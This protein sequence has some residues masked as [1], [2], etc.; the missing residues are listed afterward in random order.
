MF[1]LSN[2]F[3]VDWEFLTELLGDSMNDITSFRE[4]FLLEIR[5]FPG[6]KT[7]TLRPFNHVDL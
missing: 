5:F 1:T 7:F 2:L 3:G 4:V 6:I